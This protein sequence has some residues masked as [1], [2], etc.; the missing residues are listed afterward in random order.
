MSFVYLKPQKY[1]RKPWFIDKRCRFLSTRVLV[2]FFHLLMRASVQSSFLQTQHFLRSR[3]LQRDSIV[4]MHV[5]NVFLLDVEMQG[6]MKNEI[7]RMI[8]VYILVCN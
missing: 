4:L 2:Q 3:F 8:F 6:E 1:G 5:L 7:K